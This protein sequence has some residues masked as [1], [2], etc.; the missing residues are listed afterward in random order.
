MEVRHLF[1]LHTLKGDRRLGVTEHAAEQSKDVTKAKRE[2]NEEF[3]QYFLSSSH[4][5]SVVSDTVLHLNTFP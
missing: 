1:N 4:T 3:A 2:K 5:I